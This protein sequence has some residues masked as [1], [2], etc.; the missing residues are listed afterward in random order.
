MRFSYRALLFVL[1]LL[2]IPPAIAQNDGIE[3][4]GGDEEGLRQFISFLIFADL[5]LEVV[6]PDVYVGQGLINAPFE[7]PLPEDAD[8]VG[9]LD[10]SEEGLYSISDQLMYETSLTPR[11]VATYYAENLGD[12]FQLPSS[13]VPPTDG[14]LIIETA[15]QHGQYC[16]NN[17]EGILT[18]VIV[19]AREGSHVTLYIGD[20]QSAEQA[21]ITDPLETQLPNAFRLLPELP[22]PEGARVSAGYQKPMDNGRAGGAFVEASVTATIVTDSLTAKDLIEFYSE[23]MTTKG[24]SISYTHAVADSG[25]LTFTLTNE[26]GLW[27]GLLTIVRD[28]T[29]ENE[30]HANVGVYLAEWEATPG[31]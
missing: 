5:S 11:A 30:F 18:L 27:G 15:P 28:P 26:H 2:T 19:P 1:V 20:A 25:S 24:W 10:Y 9:S 12:E 14:G 16:Y 7:V 13:Y 29:S 21:C 17:G 23:Q 8:L 22:S 31:D 3:I 4:I 6:P